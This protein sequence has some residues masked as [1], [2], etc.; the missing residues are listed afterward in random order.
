MPEVVL[1]LSALSTDQGFVI[2]GDAPGDQAGISV[3]SAG[4]VNGDGI[5]DL[6]VGVPSGDN[7]GTNAGEA[8]VIYGVAGATRISVDL[9]TLSADEG[10]VIQGDTAGD[11]AGLS[12]AAAGDVNGDGIDDL[13]VGAPEGDLGGADAGQA[14]VIYGVAAPR[15][16]V[17]LSSLALSEGYVIT[18][19]LAGDAAGYSVAAAGDVNGDGIG[20]LIVG[21]PSGDNGGSGAGEAYVIY[22]VAGS[23]RPTVDL[24]TLTPAQGFV[25]VAEAAGDSAGF[26]VSSAGDV[27]GDGIDDLFVGAPLADDGGFYAGAA[28]V[29]YGVAGTGRSLVDLSTLTPAE[30]FVLQ[31]GAAFDLA[32]SSLSSAG[33]VN[34]DGI[35]DLILGA[36]YADGGATDAG[37]A[38]VIYGVAGT[39]R[40]TLD[41]SSLTPADGFVIQG[42]QASDEAGF[43]V[44]AAGDVNG[45]GIA[46]LIVGAPFG[47]D[48]GI[49]AGEAYVVYG[50]AGTT[51]GTVDLT[52][53][54]ASQGFAIQGD[55]AGDL[56]GWS[57]SAAGDVNGDGVDDLIVG[58]P[59]GDDG[60]TNAGEAYVIYGFRNPPV[61]TGL[62]E[63]FIA[64]EDVAVILNLSA[65][66]IDDVDPTGDMRLVIR[67][68]EGQLLGTSTGTVTA[69]ASD[70]GRTLTLTGTLAEL[71]AY[72]QVLTNI[73][74]LGAPNAAGPASDTL[75]VSVDDNDG[76]GLI[77]V[78]SITV[79]ITPVADP[80]VVAIPLADQDVQAGTPLSY[81]IPADAFTDP[82]GDTLVLTAVLIGGDPLPDWLSF[83][84]ATG[85]FSGTPPAGL[86]ATFAVIVTASDGSASVSDRF[87]ITVGAAAP[88]AP[89]VVAQ[90]LAD[91]AGTAADPLGFI[92]PAEAFTDPDGDPLTL[93]AT[94]EGGAPLPGW[95]DFDAATGTFSGTPPAGFEGTLQIEVTASDGDFGVADVFALSITDPDP[96]T[97]PAPTRIRRRA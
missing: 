62:P 86:T 77:E 4:D 96:D 54:T 90:P 57:V 11:Q 8:Y 10:F 12:V 33:D 67:A 2:I 88:N 78:G 61:A 83:D 39:G 5:D 22:G 16:T 24:S 59:Q 44:A 30:G 31:G 68:T 94:L 38:Y 32:G 15:G 46:D 23:D 45:D 82:D 76:S 64:T 84:A 97:D 19:D 56:A 35:D 92:L 34:G 25:I 51:R 41:L 47:D 21:A 55:A 6:I 80:P 20:D 66:V 72:L 87:D 50:V 9:S 40:T 1:D 71:N 42:D 65:V 63:R 91:Q 70:D 36:P 93:T 81:T 89:P 85:T 73:R 26:S 28:Y 49:A 3:A 95:L 69:T 43:S 27:N 7:G 29:V 79:D 17:D 58:A 60:G 74:Y 18:G 48:G 13:I 52:T 37:A 14:Y 53:L 75:L